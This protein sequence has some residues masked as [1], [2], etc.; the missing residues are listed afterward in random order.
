M[1]SNRFNVVAAVFAAAC[2]LLPA[3][4]A[5]QPGNTYRVTITNL[6]PGQPV[7]P[8]VVATHNI[9]FHLFVPGTAAPA[10]LVAVAEEGDPSLLVAALEEIG[11]VHDVAVGDGPLMPGQSTTVEVQARGKAVFLSA[12]GMLGSTNDAFFGL[13]GYWLHGHPWLRHTTAPAYDAGSEV[14]NE[15]CEFVPGPPC[16]GAG[17]RAPEDGVITIHSGIHG[18]GDLLPEELG[19]HNPVVRIEIQRLAGN[20]GS[21]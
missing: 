9:G 11:I 12:V 3:L 6:T 1:R 20:A 8:P 7:S 16:S 18:I 15:L 19:W 4:A 2:L 21:P 13:D 17:S 10:P 14:N 5:A